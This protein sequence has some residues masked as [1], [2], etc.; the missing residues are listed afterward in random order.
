MSSSHLVIG[1]HQTLLPPLTLYPLQQLLETEKVR[2]WRIDWSINENSKHCLKL[3]TCVASICLPCQLICLAAK[4]ID[5]ADSHWCK[6]EPDRAPFLI[7][8]NENTA[9]MSHWPRCGR[10][11]TS[12]LQ[13]A[14]YCLRISSKCQ[15]PICL[16][17]DKSTF[18]K[19]GG[20]AVMARSAESM[21]QKFLLAIH[22]R[23]WML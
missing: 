12:P 7:M 13:I 11:I 9:Y 3:M 22:R 23:G 19:S 18:S 2:K 14:L 8:S 21:L 1:G 17:E 6:T 16:E 20:V 15:H 4:P 5:Q 10:P